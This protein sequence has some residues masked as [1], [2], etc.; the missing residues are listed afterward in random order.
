M[1]FNM[2]PELIVRTDMSSRI[3]REGADH[4]IISSTECKALSNGRP[5]THHGRC[6]AAYGEDGKLINKNSTVYVK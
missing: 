2:C 1:H 3:L 6:I 5:C 4:G